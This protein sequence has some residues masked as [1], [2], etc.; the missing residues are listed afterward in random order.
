[1]YRDIDGTY[2]NCLEWLIC[3]G[4]GEKETARFKILLNNFSENMYTIYFREKN[5]P[6]LLIYKK[7]WLCL[8]G[9]YACAI[10]GSKCE[11]T[12]LKKIKAFQNKSLRTIISAIWLVKTKIFTNTSKCHIFKT[13]FH[14]WVIVFSS[15]FR[16]Q[17]DQRI[18]NSTWDHSINAFQTCRP[19]DLIV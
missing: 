17:Q 1:M 4:E 14:I 2:I 10:W 3:P 19:H 12:H 8:L 18:A 5:I 15:L 7:I 16:S 6:Y 9:T 11:F 13:T